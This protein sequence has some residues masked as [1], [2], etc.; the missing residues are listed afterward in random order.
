[1]SISFFLQGEREGSR[2]SSHERRACV[3]EANT[4]KKSGGRGRAGV[5]DDDD[6]ERMK[7]D[8]KQKGK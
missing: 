8:A 7:D 3:G 1:M 4:V 5:V 2:R 6:L